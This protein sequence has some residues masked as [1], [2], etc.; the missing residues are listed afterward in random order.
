LTTTAE[1]PVLGAMQS[2]ATSK[3]L[4]GS[5]AQAPMFKTFCATG[6]AA[7]ESSNVQYHITYRAALLDQIVRVRHLLKRQ[8][9]TDGVTQ[10]SGPQQGIE[11]VEDGPAIVAVDFVDQEELHRGGV[12]HQPQ[13]RQG[14]FAR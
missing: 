5:S 14:R 10:S 11:L 4:V 7:C 1:H 12:L 13:A 8:P 9:P 6:P 2:L 3:R